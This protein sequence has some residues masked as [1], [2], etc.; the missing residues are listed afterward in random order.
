MESIFKRALRVGAATG[1]IGVAALVPMQWA[2]SAH[3]Q[4]APSLSSNASVFAA[5]LTNPRGLTFGPDGNL[6]VAE[7]GPATNT[8]STVGQCAQVPSAGPYLGGFNSRISKI[9][10]AGVR[11]TVADNLPS[12]QTNADLG[13]LPSG[14]ADV[15]FLNGVLYGIEAGAGC[16]HGLAGTNNTLF[17]VN[18]DGTTTN[19]A[20]LSTFV[21]NNPT[22]KEN[23]ED[24]EPDGTFYSM[25]VVG[26][27]IYVVEP[28][29][30]EIDSIDPTTGAIHRLVDVSATFGHIVPT[31]IAY[32]GNFYVGN[33]NV[34][35]P[36]A[37]GHA[38]IYRVTPSGSISQ[39]ATG[40]TAVTGVVIRNGILY[41]LEAFTGDFAPGPSTVGTG[42]IARVNGDG[43]LTTVATGLT[44][45]TAMTVGPDGALYVSNNGF[46]IPVAGAGQI[47]RVTVPAAPPELQCASDGTVTSSGAT[48][49][50]GLT[51]S[52]VSPAVAATFS[53][54]TASASA[55][56]VVTS[57]TP[58]TGTVAGSMTVAGV[59]LSIPTSITVPSYVSM[60]ARI[61]V[62]FLLPGGQ[63]VSVSR[64]ACGRAGPM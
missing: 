6:Y 21:K 5:G 41:A 10:A 32:Q 33:L 39:V 38:G 28:N 25:V 36:G 56:G 60:G 45:P 29:H 13:N 50:S 54:I 2:S 3:A 8:K 4:A 31:S 23:P 12:S 57:Y 7:G 59:A 16:S 27:K 44:F 20:D 63:L 40:L 46:G 24:F 15:R 17:R 49:V 26:G 53:G 61:N 62:G 14:V 11:S 30:G 58:P 47:V 48:S 37:N 18:A 1:L 55:C 35:D 42:T 43:T 51:C 9:S 19:V 64:S 34:F 22:A 52:P